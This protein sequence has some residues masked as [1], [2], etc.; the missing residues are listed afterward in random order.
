[1]EPLLATLACAGLHVSVLHILNACSN[2]KSVDLGYPTTIIDCSRVMG[3]VGSQSTFRFMK[4]LV[5]DV[6]CAKSSVGH[7]DCRRRREAINRGQEL[8]GS[9]GF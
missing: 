7:V 8:G 2:A 9:C 1:M 3:G 4:N 6:K 5:W